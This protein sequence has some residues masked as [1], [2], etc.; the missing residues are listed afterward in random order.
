MRCAITSF[1]GWVEV[2]LGDEALFRGAYF[3]SAEEASPGPARSKEGHLEGGQRE[4]PSQDRQGLATAISPGRPWAGVARCDVSLILSRQCQGGESLGP[5]AKAGEL[6]EPRI[7][8]EERGVP[9]STRSQRKD[10]W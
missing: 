10:P 8:S 1:V 9:N 3:R 4:P 7:R 6:R 2:F 5:S